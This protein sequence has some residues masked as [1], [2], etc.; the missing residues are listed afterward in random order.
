[1]TELAKR[2]YLASVQKMDLVCDIYMLD[3]ERKE[4][5]IE[6]LD[7]DNKECFAHINF[8]M[9]NPVYDPQEY[10]FRRFVQHTI[11]KHL[12]E[13]CMAQRKVFGLSLH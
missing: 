5:I 10:E 1:M 6:F 13:A 7:M 9:H 3:E 8:T 4:F 12:V 2:I 11:N